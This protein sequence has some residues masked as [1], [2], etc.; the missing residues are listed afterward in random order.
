MTLAT[1][2]PKWNTRGST[3]LSTVAVREYGGGG[4]L[5]KTVLELDAVEV[6]VGNTTG[7]SFGGTK[8]YT[9]PDGLIYTAG[10]SVVDLTLGFANAGNATP[11]AGTHG[12]DVSLGSTIAGDGSLTAADVNIMA[13][14]SWDPLSTVLSAV[15]GTGAGLDGTSTAEDVWLNMIIDDGDVADAASDI[16]EVSGFV[17]VLWT[18]MGDT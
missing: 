14:T 18:L 1:V 3:A 12:G 13:S 11:L 7:V 2:Y 9:F 10:G 8:L 6:A 17:T 5:N 4:G 15:S 16:L